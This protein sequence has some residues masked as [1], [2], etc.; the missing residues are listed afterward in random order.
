M[1]IVCLL[2]QVL[3]AGVLGLGSNRHKP[4]PAIGDEMR[5][6]RFALSLAI[7]RLTHLEAI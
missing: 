4:L 1:P 3:S 7:L 5:R 2:R 6:G